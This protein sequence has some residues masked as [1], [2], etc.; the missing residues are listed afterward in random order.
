MPNQSE[1]TLLCFGDSNTYGVVP[2]TDFDNVRRHPVDDRWPGVV[3]QRLG[4]HWQVEADGLPSRTTVHDDPVEGAHLNGLR[5]LPASLASR[6]PLS[7]VAIMLGTNDLKNRFSVN[8]NDIAQSA[9]RLVDAVRASSTGPDGGAPRVLLIAPPP[10]KEVGPIGEVFVGAGTKSA[11]LGQTFRALAEQ[12]GVEFI[13][14]GPVAESS[15]RDGI[16]LEADSHHNLGKAVA[17]KLSAMR[18]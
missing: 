1:K 17:D 11:S 15:D 6:A 2:L 3:A 18:L 7:A 16:H 8:A 13:D 5:V 12:K 4:G 14:A 9:G 10:V